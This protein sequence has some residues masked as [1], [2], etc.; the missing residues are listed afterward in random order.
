MSLYLTS[1]S[2]YNILRDSGLL[3]IPAPSTLAGIKKDHK[4]SPGGD[5]SIYKSFLTEVKSCEHDFLG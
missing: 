2:G 3:S 5:P 4:I 1:K